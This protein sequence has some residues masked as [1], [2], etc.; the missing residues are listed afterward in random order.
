MSTLYPSILNTR[1]NE[2]SMLP[3]SSTPIMLLFTS[4]SLCRSGNLLLKRQSYRKSSPIA[5]SR[6]DLDSTAVGGDDAIDDRKPQP[7]P[8]SQWLRGKERVEYPLLG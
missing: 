1:K 7:G 5:R 4:A 8:L 2:L 6:L 3:S